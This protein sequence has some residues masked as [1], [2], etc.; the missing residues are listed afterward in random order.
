VIVIF[1]CL[2]ILITYFSVEAV[3]AHLRRRSIKLRIAVTGVRG[4]SSVTRLIA[5]ILQQNHLN[6]LGKVTGSKP[7]LLYP[8]GTEVAINRKKK[9]SIL[10]QV[11]VF[12]RTASQLSVEGF[13][14]ETMSVD[15]EILRCEIQNILKPRIIVIA[16][17]SVDHTDQLGE[18]IE[19]VR[20]NI[21]RACSAGSIIVT[22]K[23][24]LDSA[25]L[26]I[27][28]KKRCPVIETDIEQS[29]NR[30]EEY[31][32]FDE[33]MTLAIAACEV[34]GIVKSEIERTLQ[35][36][37]GDIGALR[38]WKLPSRVIAINA[39]AANDPDST[40]KV[41]EKAR[42][43]LSDIVSIEKF[44]GVLNLRSDRVDRTIQWLEQLKNWFPFEKLYVLGSDNRL[45]TRKLNR[46]N[47]HAVRIDQFL[48]EIDKFDE[49]TVVFGF[50]N[51]ANDG[52]KLVDLWQERGICLKSR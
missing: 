27:L 35:K 42:E 16:R 9:P 2:A 32:E 28:K 36:I 33:N 21:V 50:G 10:E 41:F 8:D 34:A 4:K 30:P 47:C 12:L 37:R 38:C 20:M 17:L 6:V 24:N 26:K 39:F 48:T 51:I 52:M 25:S 11:R 45:F 1:L 7:V 29:S 19:Q 18:S 5:G 14:C 40:I 46:S 43:F 23:G 22:T 31:L 44:V 49:G 15:P 3:H 13:V